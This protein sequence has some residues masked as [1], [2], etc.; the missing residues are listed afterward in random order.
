MIE[1]V[2]H[3]F[4]L[5]GEHHHPNIF[6]LFTSGVGFVGVYSYIKYKYFTKKQNKL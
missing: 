4:G 5:C 2:R 6:T 1:I 3:A